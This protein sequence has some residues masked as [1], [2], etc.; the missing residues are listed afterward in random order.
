MLLSV[1]H[2]CNVTANDVS[3]RPLH[4]T[5]HVHVPVDNERGPEM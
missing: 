1:L 5:L 3:E 4:D 2:A